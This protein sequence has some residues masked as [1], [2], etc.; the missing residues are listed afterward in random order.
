[1]ADAWRV[2][3][4]V[5]SAVRNETEDLLINAGAVVTS[6]P[7]PDDDGWRL[8]LVFGAEPDVSLLNRK[9]PGSC[10]AIDADSVERLGDRDWVAASRSL[11]P[12]LRVGRFQVFEGSARNQR[13]AGGIG[14]EVEASQAFGTGHH[15]STQGCL[16]AL[17]RLARR[18]KISNALDV[19]C[20]SGILSVAIGK[21]WRQPL[22]AVDIDAKSLEIAS[23]TAESNAVSSLCTFVRSD[24][25]NHPAI[26]NR[27]PCDLIVANILA[28]PL[29]QMAGD[30]ARNAGRQSTIIL[31]GLLIDHGPPLL[32]RYCG[33]GF[34]L[35]ERIVVGGWVTLVLG[36]S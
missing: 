33:F 8:D 22:L 5:P 13:M 15:G 34:S 11:R 36:K 31:S 29:K 26:R 1:M 9:L 35:V 7:V 2:S 30:M 6:R 27:A 14:I 16:L 32:A 21:L 4:R 24:G 23:K 25:F 19:G 10:P 17:D 18:A 12:L 20:G 28:G 3:L